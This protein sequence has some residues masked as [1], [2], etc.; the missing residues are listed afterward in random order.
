[1]ERSYQPEYDEGVQKSPSPGAVRKCRPA[2]SSAV[3]STKRVEQNPLKHHDLALTASARWRCSVDVAQ[4]VSARVQ[5]RAAQARSLPGKPPKASNCPVPKTA[6]V[7]Q[8]CRLVE[9]IAPVP[10][11]FRSSHSQQAVT[12]D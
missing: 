10:K 9:R 3:P 11:E 6:A 12:C 2:D 5:R 7:S 4:S 8:R 1:M